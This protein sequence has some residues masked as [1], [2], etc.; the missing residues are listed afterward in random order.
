MENQSNNLPSRAQLGLDCM[1]GETP[2]KRDAAKNLLAMLKEAGVKED[3]RE[4]QDS[5]WKAT[6][7][8]KEI[9]MLSPDGRRMLEMFEPDPEQVQTAEPS[10]VAPQTSPAP[11]AEPASPAEITDDR[12]NSYLKSLAWPPKAT[13]Q[14]KTPVDDTT[15]HR[16]QAARPSPPDTS[17]QPLPP[18]PG[19]GRP[20]IDW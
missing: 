11:T 8:P 17:Q 18:D 6:L 10:N 19:E 4:W 3:P 2:E 12:V 9:L 14:P 7:P 5:A 16:W 15:P 13:P 1:F 20:P